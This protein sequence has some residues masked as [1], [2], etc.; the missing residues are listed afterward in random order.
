MFIEI[1]NTKDTEPQKAKAKG[2]AKTKALKENPEPRKI[3]RSG[4]LMT[5][6]TS[7]KNTDEILHYPDMHNKRKFIKQKK[8]KIRYSINYVITCLELKETKFL[9]KTSMK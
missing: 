7:Y 2:K 8:K 3:K 9:T 5:M 4:K 1:Q 6:K